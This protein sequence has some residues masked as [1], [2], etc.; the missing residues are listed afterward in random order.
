MNE[1]CGTCR[2]WEKHARG[3]SGNCHRMPPTAMLIGMAPPA[4]VGG[5][6]QPVVNTFWIGTVPTDW[7]GE[8]QPQHASKIDLGRLAPPPVLS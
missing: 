2:F 3:P 4:M 6:P 5:P 8:Y 7:C 1:T